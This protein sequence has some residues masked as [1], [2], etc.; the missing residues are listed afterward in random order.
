MDISG[1]PNIIVLMLDTFRADYLKDYGGEG[2]LRVLENICRKGIVFKKAVAPATYTVPSHISLF[3]GKRVTDIEGWQGW[4]D[5]KISE[6]LPRYIKKGS[7]TLAR[8]LEYVGYKTALFSSNPFVAVNTGIGDGFSY[9]KNSLLEEGPVE[10]NK[11]FGMLN[12][13]VNSKAV[14]DMFLSL[15][16]LSGF[17]PERTSR[18]LFVGIEKMLERKLNKETRYVDLDMGAKFI[19][20]SIKKYLGDSRRGG[21]FIFVNYME[22][23]DAYPISLITDEQVVQDRWLYMGGFL[24]QKEVEFGIDTIKKA[25]YRR[26]QYLDAQ[27]GKLLDALKKKG[28]LDNAVLVVTSDHGQAFMEHG[29]MYHDLFPYSEMVDIPLVVAEFVNGVQV[30]RRQTIS[31]AVSLTSL[32]NMLLDVAYGKRMDVDAAIREFV[33][34]D[35]IGTVAWWGSDIIKRLKGKHVHFKRLAD[36]MQE[37]DVFATAVYH[38]N[39]KLIHYSRRKEDELYDISSDPKESHNIVRKKRDI[40]KR[41]LRMI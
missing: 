13:V 25:C 28:I 34:S 7:L 27:I 40:Y 15:V 17:L 36:L 8:K 4:H 12:M 23:H 24:D 31:S 18:K 11:S 3:L 21:N 5:A 33:V 38:K 30:N 9:E 35:H 20:E 16:P 22:A 19:N 37:Y 1:R 41:M 6:K 29:Q 2:N 39:Y 14:Q 10:R 32:H 26:L